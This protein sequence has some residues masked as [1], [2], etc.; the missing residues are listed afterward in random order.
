MPAPIAVLKR[1]RLTSA[2]T[3][4]AQVIKSN[5]EIKLVVKRS[6]PT[7]TM[8]VVRAAM[9][10]EKKNTDTSSAMLTPIKLRQSGP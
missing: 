6:R 10:G 2:L 1:C 4:A 5:A 8:G 9:I 3:R 7:A